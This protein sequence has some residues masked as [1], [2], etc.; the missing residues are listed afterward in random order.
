MADVGD[1][2]AAAL[3]DATLAAG[4]ISGLVVLAMLHCRQPAR[5]RDWARAGL[6]S[7]LALFPLAA[8][9]PDRRVDLS[10]PL[11]SILGA[12]PV[13]RLGG[14]FGRA[15]DATGRAGP[16]AR[17]LVL[18]YG[19]GA[20]AGLAWVALGF[21]GSAWL[22][23]RA[24]AASARSR[25]LLDS[26]PFEGRGGRPRLLVSGRV[27]RPV[28]VGCFRPAILIPGELEGPGP[29]D[30]LRLSLLHELAH[31][32]NLDHCFGPLGGLARAA[33]FFLPPV[34]WMVDQM[35]LDQEFLAD[36][37]AVAHFGSSGGYASSLVEL[38]GGGGTAPPGGSGAGSAPIRTD[39]AAGVASALVQR[40]MM[41]L[42]CPFPIEGRSPGWWRWSTALT[43]A[44]ATLA[45]S[46]LTLR[47]LA[48]GPASP[49]SP[50]EEAPR[51][52]RLPELTITQRDHD[53]RPFDL[54][55]RLP[56]RFT[57]SFEM[58]AEPAG[59]AGV[60]ALGHRLAP[61]GPP[62]PGEAV[63]EGPWHRVRIVRSG[64]AESVEV[65]GRPAAPAPGPARL[66]PWLTIRPSPGQTAKIRDLVLE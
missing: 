13:V 43:L 7:A 38:A 20:S 39:P 42:R 8:F 60:E 2:L 50:A 28:L 40:V 48:V 57:L 26:L 24:S 4:A 22:V 52:F 58:E 64:N 55:F 61:A 51:S 34:W 19:V 9:H 12:D 56:E 6:I 27:A 36:R 14:P 46:S 33:W 18:A 59:P 49:D 37:R 47:G 30:R 11:R 66:T 63:A 17:G 29:V 45:A 23:G 32:E 54:R 15:A 10:G 62:R 65:D 16:V 53:D 35:R 41:L 31:A 21:F 5:R 3:L 44:L 1:R 25:A